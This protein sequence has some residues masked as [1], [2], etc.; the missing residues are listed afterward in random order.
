M[1]KEKGKKRGEERVERVERVGRWG[2]GGGGGCNIKRSK[3]KYNVTLSGLGVGCEG[4]KGTF[5]EAEDD[6]ESARRVVSMITRRGGI[7]ES[8]LMKAYPRPRLK[9]LLD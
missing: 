3:E 4:I 7:F 8:V 2:G 9:P 1:Q 6:S 5:E